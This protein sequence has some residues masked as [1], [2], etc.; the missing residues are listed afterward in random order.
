[1]WTM[2]KVTMRPTMTIAT[3]MPMPRPAL[4]PDVSSRLNIVLEIGEADA[5]LIV[6][7]RRAARIVRGYAIVGDLEKERFQVR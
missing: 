1:M 5:A 6:V 2:K 7:R 3:A 4:A